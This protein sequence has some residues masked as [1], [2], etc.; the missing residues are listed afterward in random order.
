MVIANTLF[1]QHKRKLYTWT[2]PDGQHQNQTDYILCSQRWRSSIQSAKTRLGAHCGSDM[3]SSLT[4]SQT[5]YMCTYMAHG[6]CVCT[7]ISV[8]LHAPQ[9]MQ[10]RV[11]CFYH[12]L[13]LML[14]KTEGK[15]MTEHED[16]VVW[17]HR[18][19]NGR[20]CEQAPGDGEGQGSLAC[21]SPRGRKESD[22]TDWLNN[23]NHLL[24]HLSLKSCLMSF[25]WLSLKPS[26]S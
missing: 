4:V 10:N 7:G 13:M 23:N 19:L 17:W 18:Q 24:K 6:D 5:K 15:R 12:L 25:F 26:N 3:N 2:S 20:K 16:E 21:C 11:G 9:S 14:R 22:T 8:A 1:Q